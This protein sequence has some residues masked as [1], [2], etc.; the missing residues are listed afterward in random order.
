MFIQQKKNKQL[1]GSVEQ[2]S[3]TACKRSEKLLGFILMQK[4]RLSTQNTSYD[5]SFWKKLRRWSFE[6]ETAGIISIQTFDN[7]LHQKFASRRFSKPFFHTQRVSSPTA[8]KMSYK[9][10]TATKM[11]KQKSDECQFAINVFKATEMS[12]KKTA[13]PPWENFGAEK[14]LPNIVFYDPQNQ[15]TAATSKP[16]IINIE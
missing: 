15:E 8:T 12:M 7:F 1:F 3:I 14:E 13:R 2:K 11:S 10:T 16:C 6:Q 4:A 9:K 5:I